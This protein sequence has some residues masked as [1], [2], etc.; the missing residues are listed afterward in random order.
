MAVT[1]GFYNSLNKDRMYNAE[2]MSS[3]F[4]GIITDGVF[5][6]VG[7]ALMTVAGSGMQVIVKTGRAWFNSTWTLNDAQLPLDVPTADVSLTRIDAVILEVNSAVA[8]R[9]N[10]IKILKGTPS[11]NP[12][13]PTLSATETNHQYALAYITVGA[14][15]TS[16]TAANIE[17]NVGKSTCPFITSVLQQTDI[18][19]LFN[20][21]EAE[22]TAWFENVQS[23]LSGDVAANL[24]R[25]I[26][27]KVD[28]SDKATDEDIE[29][30][31]SG[32][33]VD[34]AHLGHMDMIGDIKL[35]GRSTL[36]SKWLPCDGRQ[37]SSTDY[38]DLVD[39][40]KPE[41]TIG[42]LAVNIG[43]IEFEQGLYYASHDVC[44]THTGTILFVKNNILYLWKNGEISSTNIPYIYCSNI[45]MS[46]SVQPLHRIKHLLIDDN[47]YY[48]FMS[49]LSVL[50]VVN[51]DG[52]LVST[53]N[54]NISGSSS[55]TYANIL[56]F[57][58]NKNGS[59]VIIGAKASSGST[60][61]YMYA[62]KNAISFVQ[63]SQ[64]I[65][66]TY[67]HQDPSYR[68]YCDSIVVGDYILY[69][70]ANSNSSGSEKSSGYIY[71]YKFGDTDYIGT[72]T[73]SESASNNNEFLRFIDTISDTQFAA[74]GTA[75]RTVYLYTISNLAV[76]P[77]RKTLTVT[78]SKQ[79][80]E[81]AFNFWCDANYYYFMG[82]TGIYKVNK[83]DLN[84]EL[85]PSKTI[86]TA[87]D[88]TMIFAII[89]SSTS[90]FV[91]DQNNYSSSSIKHT[92][93]IYD[94]A[95]VSLPTIQNDEYRAFI[96]ALN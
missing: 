11:A 80:T 91:L 36:G 81:D 56:D 45:Y 52:E 67:F 64:T 46:S 96:K 23:Q 17:I 65:N 78:A 43:A 22:F 18:T 42:G 37:I 89:N 83:I 95:A 66:V 44:V 26:D 88:P 68:D 72:Y 2:Q 15:V 51:A 70:E 87:D 48:Y 92:G 21:W 75:D 25:Q 57:R 41:I 79:L 63:S 69:M 90:E 86:E 19:D 10:S 47:H 14:G 82:K 35:T 8:T 73:F 16:I 6:T 3:I 77:S 50:R 34:A 38:P 60:Y 53:V 61:I 9:A 94:T 74:I 62:A 32:K 55:P 54:I 33:W 39:V 93:T 7:D 49:S 5:S 13:K 59:V 58:I 71:I 1:Y 29:N 28:L 40:L 20:Q 85:V 12:A 31:T 27:L 4:N 24:Q 76:N 30:E 84:Y